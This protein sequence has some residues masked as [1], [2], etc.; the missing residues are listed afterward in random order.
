[1]HRFSVVL[2]LASIKESPAIHVVGLLLPVLWDL[3]D[4][5]P[6]PAA[7]QQQDPGHLG[8]V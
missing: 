8:K 5:T 4:Q 3:S 6:W 7:N 1:M 2:V